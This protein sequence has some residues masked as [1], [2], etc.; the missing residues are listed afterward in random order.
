MALENGALSVGRDEL[1][2]VGMAD[3]RAS[4]HHVRVELDESGWTVSDLGSRN[5]TFMDGRRQTSVRS[6]KAPI[7]RIGKTLMLPVGN[8]RPFETQGIVVRDNVVM[9]PSLQLL[10]E[11]IRAIGRSSSSLLVLGSSGTGKELAAQAFH[12]GARPSA[13]GA[14]GPAQRPFVAV[15][16]AAIQSE[17]AE[18]VLFG[19]TRGAYTGSVADTVGLV[20]AADG[21]TL[22]LD[23]IAELTLAVQA[24]LLRVLETRSVLPLGAVTPVPV[25]VRLCAATHKDLRAEVL[26]GRFR[27]DLFFRVGRPAVHLPS[28]RE[29][30]EEIPWLVA[31][32]LSAAHAAGT[33]PGTTAPITARASFVEA[34]LLRPWPGNVRELLTEVKTA[35]LAAIATSRGELSGADL[36][37][38]AGRPHDSAAGNRVAPPPSASRTTTPD[39]EK[40]ADSVP[41]ELG[42]VETALRREQGNIARAAVR[43]GVSR[44]RLRRS[45]ERYGIDVNALRSG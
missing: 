28:L 13:Q 8:R 33:S 18:R 34:C 36:D 17:L 19:A 25:H 9:G 1:A 21:G 11:H 6:G 4:R 40:E 44:S 31:H 30:R 5:G 26:A 43:L 39:A 20:Q 37:A 42:A 23:E 32:A 15:N 41:L 24:K 35:A 45:I 3:E 38:E 27:E 7:V 2:A 16:C 29:R 22:F 12:N 14:R 10:H